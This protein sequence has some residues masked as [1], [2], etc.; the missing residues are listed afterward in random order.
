MR[1]LNWSY[2]IGCL[3]CSF[4]DK[5]LN[6]YVQLKKRRSVLQKKSAVQKIGR[7]FNNTWILGEDICIT[8]SG[9]PITSSESKYVWISNVFSGSGIPS[10]SLGCNILLPYSTEP[11]NHLLT[12]LSLHMGHNF[13]ATLLLIG[14][15]VFVLHY[16][17]LIE[18]L[19]YCPIPLAFGVSGTGKT[20]ALECVLSLFGAR[21]SRLYSKVTRAKIFDLCCEC[22]G[23]P[24]GVDVVKVT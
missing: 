23:I 6:E 1:V 13:Y 16:Q 19:R 10:P 24:L 2:R 20:T 14:S 4:N 8:S 21:D 12:T 5:D 17:E 15:A 18:Q 9:Y 22:A 7:Q 11:L 3:Q